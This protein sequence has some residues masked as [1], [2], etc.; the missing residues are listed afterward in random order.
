MNTIINSVAIMVIGSAIGAN[1]AAIPGKCSGVSIADATMST[2]ISFDNAN[3]NKDLAW[4][5]TLNFTI[6]TPHSSQAYPFQA[7]VDTG[8]MGVVVGAK[9]LGLDA[10]ALSKYPKGDSYLSSSGVYWEGYLIPTS[11]VDLTFTAANVLSKVPVLA[12]YESSICTSWQGAAGC[13]PGSKTNITEWPEHLRYLGV[14]FGRWSAASPDLPNKNPLLNVHSIDGVAVN[15]QNMHSGYVLTSSGVHIG[16]TSANTQD[17]VSTPLDIT[18]SGVYNDWAAPQV[19]LAVDNSEWSYG[20]ALFD[21]GISFSYVKLNAAS[22]ALQRKVVGTYKGVDHTVLSPESTMH[23][24]IGPTGS[25]IGW[26]NVRAGNLDNPMRPLNG[27]FR[28]ESASDTAFINTGR[29]FYRGFD[30]FLDA[31]CGNFGLRWKG[32]SGSSFGGIIQ[33]D[34]GDL[35]DTT[36]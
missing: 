20:S 9:M 12:V 29:F 36:G 3:T 18:G 11:D 15:A 27:Q 32:R 16:L 17:F 26:Y 24:K 35:N 2:F 23:M 28:P 25:H 34:H 33:G 7:S 8:S 31:T 13:K 21:T 14:G 10:A 22:T 4:D 1:A 30:T 19:A 6:K 5:M